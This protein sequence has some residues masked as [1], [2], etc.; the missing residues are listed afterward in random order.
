MAGDTENFWKDIEPTIDTDSF[1]TLCQI[2]PMN[3]TD[4]SKNPLKPKAP[5]KWV[6]TDIIPV[7]AP[8]RLTSELLFLNIF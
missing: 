8:K 7:I 6:F 2:S 5:F 4:G 3:K 1:G